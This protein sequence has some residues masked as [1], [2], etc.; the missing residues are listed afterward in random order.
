[1]PPYILSIVLSCLMPM[2]STCACLCPTKSSHCLCGLPMISLHPS[3]QALLVS[4]HPGYVSKETEFSFRYLLHDVC[5]ALVEST[6]FV[7]RVMFSTPALAPRRD[8]G[9]VLYSLLPV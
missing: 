4:I 1:M 7:R 5:G 2:S 8:L 6:P 9:Q 3:F